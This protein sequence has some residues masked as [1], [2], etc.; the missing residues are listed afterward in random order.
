MLN[1]QVNLVTALASFSRAGDLNDLTFL[2]HAERVAYTA[3][4]LGKTLGLSEHD[5]E[6]L[7][8]SSLLHDIGGLL[9]PRKNCAWPIW[10]RSGGA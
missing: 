7:L 1:I 2:A 5:L 3:F 8:L 6:E 9:R 4:R 10:S